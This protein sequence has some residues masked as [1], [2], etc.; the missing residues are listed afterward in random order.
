ML[1]EEDEEMM[2]DDDD[3]F[4]FGMYQYAL[5]IDKYM[6]RA[7]YRQP[8]VT[9]FEWVQDKLASNN[10][11]Y[12]MFRMNPSMFYSL[13]DLLVDKYDL[14][15]SSKSS[16]IE[17][18]GLFLW[19]VGAPQSVRQAEDI[20]ERSLRAV[21]NLFNKVLKCMVKLAA[22]NIK[23]VDPQFTTVHDRLRSHR[24]YPFFKDC[25]GAID[26][27]HVPCVVPSDKFMQYLCRKNI[28][29]QNVMACCDFDMR[30]TF[31]LAS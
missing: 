14:K 29:T 18:L 26:G 22:D 31:V 21:S 6:N 30:F 19:M 25:I 20:F 3:G 1:D 12:N 17:A 16:S 23:P 2:D 4:I 13:H 27:T 5:H 8:K 7:E 10:Q 28:S 11:C 9:G 15:S 24:F